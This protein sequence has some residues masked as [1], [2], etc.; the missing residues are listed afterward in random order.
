MGG[1]K[2]EDRSKDQDHVGGEG[3]DATSLQGGKQLIIYVC[4]SLSGG[5]LMDVYICR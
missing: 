5:G 1:W 4:V 3:K 2:V